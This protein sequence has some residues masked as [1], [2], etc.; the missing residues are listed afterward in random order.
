MKLQ[1]CRQCG[2]HSFTT[3]NN[4]MI[5]DYCSTAYPIADSSASTKSTTIDLNDDVKRLLEKCRKDP[6]NAHRYASLVLD[7]DPSN[8]EAG[9]Y[10]R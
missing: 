7:I 6:T 8:S 1:T 2:S 9:T 10:L 3:K 5:C 4:K